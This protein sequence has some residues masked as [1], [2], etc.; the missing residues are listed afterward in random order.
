MA[1]VAFAFG[2]RRNRRIVG[3]DDG[4]YPNLVYLDKD[5]ILQLQQLGH[6]VLLAREANQ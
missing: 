3:V 6:E 4:K 1:V 2:I 5:Q